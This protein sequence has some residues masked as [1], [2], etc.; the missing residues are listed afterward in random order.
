MVV[1]PLLIPV[2][3]LAAAVLV[4]WAQALAQVQVPTVVSV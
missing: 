1:R 3:V 4:Q 2:V